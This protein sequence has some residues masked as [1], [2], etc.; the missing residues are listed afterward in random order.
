[1]RFARLELERLED[2]LLLTGSVEN[3]PPNFELGG[4]VIPITFETGPLIPLVDDLN[5]PGEPHLDF[6]PQINPITLADP[7]HRPNLEDACYGFGEQFTQ[8]HDGDPGLQYSTT[9][10]VV[11]FDHLLFT[12]TES[13]SA[14]D[15]LT[16]QLRIGFSSTGIVSNYLTFALNTAD[17][18]GAS[19]YNYP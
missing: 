8:Q 4:V 16:C 9:T 17:H 7:G 10:E 6:V 14:G 12:Y 1:M 11:P 18:S 19:A 15:Q 13:D 3:P 5:P 2:R